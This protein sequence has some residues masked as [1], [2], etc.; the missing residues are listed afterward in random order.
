MLPFHGFRCAEDVL[1]AN[2]LTIHFSLLS[3]LREGSAWKGMATYALSA[4][5]TYWSLISSY[6][7]STRL[8]VVALRALN[9]G[10]D[11]AEAR[12]R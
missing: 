3:I 10:A 1:I 11:Q 12:D 6:H 9:G 8:D 2:C 7:P 5:P 4:M